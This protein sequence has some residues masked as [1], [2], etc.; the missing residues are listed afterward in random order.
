MIRAEHRR[1]LE[2]GSSVGDESSAPIGA[3]SI[4][5]LVWG[6]LSMSQADGGSYPASDG[7]ASVGP[8]P[9]LNGVTP[10][11]VASFML[12]VGGRLVGLDAGAD[13]GHPLVVYTFEV[14]GKQ[15]SFEVAVRD[16]VVESIAQ[17]FPEAA[18]PE[19]ALHARLGITFRPPGAP[20]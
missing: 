12:D 8:P 11:Q 13:A 1:I 9:R 15:Q 3:C 4:Q 10:A 19:A 7:A 5:D 16:G 14:A 20:N 2:G 6:V 18:R 17:H